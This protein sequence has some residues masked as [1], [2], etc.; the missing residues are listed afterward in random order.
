MSTKFQ[1]FDQHFSK[2]NQIEP[3][4][5]QIWHEIGKYFITILKI[6]TKFGQIRPKTDQNLYKFN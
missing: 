4:F 5:D 2:L 1:R 3:K 6:W